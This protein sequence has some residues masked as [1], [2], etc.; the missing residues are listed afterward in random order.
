MKNYSIFFILFLGTIW[1]SNFIYMK[2]AAVYLDPMQVTFYRILFG[3][4]P[5][6][7]FAIYKK[8]LK[9]EHLRYSI[10][11][12][13][14]SLLAAVVYYYGFV[15]GS[16]LLLSGVAGA[17]SASIPIFS[18]LLAAFFLKEE[19]ITKNALLGLILGFFGVILI[20][21]I[22]SEDLQNLNLEGI[23]SIILGSL[24]VGASFIYAKKFLMPLKI[25][26]TALTTY[27]LSFA[28]II[29][30]FLVDFDGIN[31]IWQ[32]THTSLGMVFGLGIFG[33]GIAFIMYYFS[34]EKFGALLASSITYIPPIVALIIGYF[35]VG[36]ELKLIDFFAT[37]LIFLGVFLINK[38]KA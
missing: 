37:G 9:F 5:V 3:L 11:F 29:M 21:G 23:V 34:I 20:S 18:F 28:L 33:T 30:I 6:L 14:M 35:I 15:K 13:V 36:E 16:Y 32:D 2:M 24:S 19:K 8:A 27:Q 12:F 38:R 22:F 31:N 25:N 1:G 26:S 7:A 17:L 10:H 4:I